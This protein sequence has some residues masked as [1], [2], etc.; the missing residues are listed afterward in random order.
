MYVNED[1]TSLKDILK[2]LFSASKGFWL[3]NAV[4]F[5][6]GIAYFGMLN[7]MTLFLGPVANGM[8]M[9]SAEHEHS[10]PPR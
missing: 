1:K 8:G 3:V 6:D 7:L 4:N 9:G 10:L 2:L 5:G